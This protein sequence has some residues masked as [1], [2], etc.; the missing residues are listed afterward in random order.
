MAGIGCSWQR[1]LPLASAAARSVS[2]FRRP[3]APRAAVYLMLCF[4][5]PMVCVDNSTFAS[6]VTEAVAGASMLSAQCKSA[7]DSSISAVSVP[8]H[9]ATSL[10]STRCASRAR[11]RASLM[12]AFLLNVF[13]GRALRLLVLRGDLRHNLLAIPLGPLS[14]VLPCKMPP[15]PFLRQV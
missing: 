12:L 2:F 6:A 11:G 10:P 8:S 3:A 1:D 5:P 13:R 9:L 7:R 14:L 4:D 15:S